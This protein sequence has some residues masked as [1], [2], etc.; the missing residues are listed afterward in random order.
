MPT[1][2][3]LKRELLRRFSHSDHDGMLIVAF[4][5]GTAKE[6]LA[7]IEESLAAIRTCDPQRYLRLRRDLLF[8]VV[9]RAPLRAFSRFTG[10]CT[11][12]ERTVVQRSAGVIA[13]M[14]VH[15]A[16]QARF[17]RAG[18]LALGPRAGRRAYV[19][20]LREQIAFMEQLARAGWSNTDGYVNWLRGVIA[21]AE[22]GAA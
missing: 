6:A 5:R 16:T 15:V 19:R 11:L 12:P 17:A 9:A 7:K 22:S 1:F 18:I 21:D 13:G 8:V 14:I 20:C 4:R 10:T 2:V 3:R